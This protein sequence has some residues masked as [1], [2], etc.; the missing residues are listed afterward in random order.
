MG[1]EVHYK[2]LFPGYH[3]MRNVDED[4]N[5]NSWHLFNTLTS[6]H[7]YEGF[8]PRTVT[9]AYAGHDKDELKQK[10][11][12]HET[13]FK[14]QVFFALSLFLFSTV[15]VHIQHQDHYEPKNLCR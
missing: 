7:Y 6:G 9:D 10:M 5:S 13:V 11:L 12:Q 2:N 4:S 1:T 8:T 15:N 3:S 14:N